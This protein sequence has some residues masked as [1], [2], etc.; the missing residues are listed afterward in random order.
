MVRLLSPATGV[1]RPRQSLESDFHRL[2]R[3]H[4]DNFRAVYAERYA[5]RIGY[6][7]PVI[8]KAMGKLL[9]CGDL[10]HG[11][12]RARCPSC[13][14][15]FFVAF[16]CKQRCICPSCAQ[17]RTLLTGLHVADDVCRAVPQPLQPRPSCADHARWQ[18]H[19]PGR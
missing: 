14:H 1:Y 19:L 8:D 13:H 12:A 10:N 3:Q 2:V 11:F 5:D 6:W 7:R 4:F 15:E 17:K 18:G 9:K 16:S